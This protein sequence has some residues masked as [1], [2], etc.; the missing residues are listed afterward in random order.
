MKSRPRPILT[1]AFLLILQTS[2]GQ[3]VPQTEQEDPPE[4]AGRLRGPGRQRGERLPLSPV[5]QISALQVES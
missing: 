1:F 2:D 5:R 3:V 4:P